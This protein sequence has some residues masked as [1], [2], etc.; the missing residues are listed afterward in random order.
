MMP[1]MDRA[2]L[3]RLARLSFG[4]FTRA[5]ARAC[6]FS[7][8]QIQR[9]I[10]AGEWQQILG[11]SLAVAG[12][13]ITPQVRDRAAQLVVPN[14][15]LAGPSAARTWQVSVPDERPYLYVGRSGG[16]RLPG[17]RL[18]YETPDRRDVSLYQGLP[19]MSRQTAVVDCL[20]ILPEPAALALADRA[21]Q[22]RWLALEDL[23]ARAQARVGLPGAPQL[24]RLVGK[25]SGG[26]RSAA[27]RLL[28]K[29]FRQS[30]PT[31]WDAN[32]EIRDSAGVIGV[33]DVAFRRVRLVIEID[34]WAFHSTPERF[35][36]DR[37]RQSRLTAA[38]WTV[39]RFT[40]RDLTERPEQVVETVRRLL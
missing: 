23:V 27:E 14:S 20:R 38:G 19:T 5:Q 9:R 13:V 16:S 39:L 35:Q 36:R 10:R 29:L 21:F 28:H 26:A 18:L 37:Q 24:R 31:G 34:G 17:V 22:Q 8:Y 11:S 30:G 32:A 3:A 25:V 12:L 7:A 4:V 40:W 2:R 15:I 1:G 6:G 33:V